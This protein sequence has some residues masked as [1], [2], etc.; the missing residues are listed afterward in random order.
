MSSPLQILLTLL[1]FLPMTANTLRR[2]R[3]QI[4]VILMKN[5]E[6]SDYALL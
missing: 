3:L 6:I 5:L 4:T 1:V 2:D